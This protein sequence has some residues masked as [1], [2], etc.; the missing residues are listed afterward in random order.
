MLL[1][2]AI[3]GGLFV[4]KTHDRNQK[5][6]KPLKEADFYRPHNHAG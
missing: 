1:L 5:Q 3:T 6:E 2:T 4:S